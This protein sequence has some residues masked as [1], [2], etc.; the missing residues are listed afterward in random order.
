MM[1]GIISKCN[2]L[3]ILPCSCFCLRFAVACQSIDSNKIKYRYLRHV[4][5]FALAL[6]VDESSLC[7][8]SQ[9]ISQ[10]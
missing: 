7:P 8:A 5:L 10:N 4:L 6:D 1:R 9:H 2:Y 3:Y